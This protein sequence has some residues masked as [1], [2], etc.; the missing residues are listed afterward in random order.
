MPL[1]TWNGHILL[2][3]ISHQASFLFQGGQDGLAL[4]DRVGAAHTAR[5]WR[6]WFPEALREPVQAQGPE[7]V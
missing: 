2:A 4:A 5:C 1:T 7:G 3:T 6:Q